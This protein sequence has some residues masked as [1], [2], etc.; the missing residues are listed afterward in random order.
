MPLTKQEQKRKE[1]NQYIYKGSRAKEATLAFV[2]RIIDLSEEVTTPDD[3]G[4]H[5]AI[6]SYLE[7]LPTSHIVAKLK[8]KIM[9]LLG[10]TLCLNKPSVLCC[11]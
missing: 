10:K 1:K 3:F 4:R 6:L 9:S 8:K 2:T 11:Q 7:K 5:A